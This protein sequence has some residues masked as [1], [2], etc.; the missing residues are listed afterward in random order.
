MNDIW[1]YFKSQKKAQFSK[2][3]HWCEE[4]LCWI[5]K[6]SLTYKWLLDGRSQSQNANKN[7]IELI[8]I[9]AEPASAPI[10]LGAY[11]P[12]T[13]QILHE[14]TES[15]WSCESFIIWVKDAFLIP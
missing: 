1:S 15:I 13:E 10:I 8:S 14:E 5:G 9:I 6:P 11:I 3:W 4:T 7:T 12:A 2:T